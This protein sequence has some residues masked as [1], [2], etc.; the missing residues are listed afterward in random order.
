MRVILVLQPIPVR[1]VPPTVAFAA[2]QRLL[3]SPVQRVG[4]RKSGT[5]K[6]G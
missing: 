3:E 1:I 2:D 4:I 5:T 6:K